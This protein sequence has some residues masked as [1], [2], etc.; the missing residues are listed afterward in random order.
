M[1]WPAAPGHPLVLTFQ[2]WFPDWQHLGLGEVLFLWFA[3][4]LPLDRFWLT[5]SSPSPIV[6]RSHALP[7]AVRT[8]AWG[9]HLLS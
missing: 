1:Q 2:L 3:A 5:I 8:P 4:L 6:G 7:G 9:K